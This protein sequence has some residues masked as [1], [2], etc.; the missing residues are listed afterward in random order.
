MTQ[1]VDERAAHAAPVGPAPFEAA[2]VP[3]GQGGFVVGEDDCLVTIAER[4]GHFWQTLWN[5]PENAALRAARKNQNVLLPGDRLTIIPLRAREA[6]CATDQRHV[7]RRV[8][9]PAYLRLR[10]SWRGKPRAGVAYR[11]DIEGRAYAGRLDDQGR[12]ALALPPMARR[13]TLFLGEA[14]DEREIPLRLGRLVPVSEIRGVKMR[15]NNLDFDAGREDDL[16][17]AAFRAALR[18][19]QRRES[20]PVTGEPDDALRAALLRVHGS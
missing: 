8:G 15:L 18:R 20:L 1:N 3:C 4:T 14:P 9:V 5:L 17:D 7:F 6:P 2:P 16:V 12:L 19:F 11:A 13:G 10:F